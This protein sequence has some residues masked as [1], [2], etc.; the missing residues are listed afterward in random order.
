MNRSSS[1]LRH[2][3][4]MPLTKGWDAPGKRMMLMNAAG[5]TDGK[6]PRRRTPLEKGRRRAAVELSRTRV[7]ITRKLLILARNCHYG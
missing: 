3:T 6:E 4:G 5:R 7:L 2:R 1:L